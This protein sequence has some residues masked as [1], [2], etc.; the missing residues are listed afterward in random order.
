M[1]IVHPKTGQVYVEKR[2]RRYNEPGQPNITS[3]E[4]LRAMI[5]YIHLNPVRRG[6]VKR[7]E[8]WEYSSARWYAG[9]RPVPI[10]MDSMI[11]EELARDGVWP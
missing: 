11:L 2:R 10:E 9:R 4:A 5:E 8:D 3:A 7:P 6:L 1:R